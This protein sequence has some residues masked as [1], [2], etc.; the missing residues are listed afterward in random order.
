MTLSYFI[1]FYY[2]W[3][4]CIE[5]DGRIRMKIRKYSSNNPLGDS[6]P[7][8]KMKVGTYAIH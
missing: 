2:K 4:H 7:I 3:L 5:C 8:I 1:M 6:T